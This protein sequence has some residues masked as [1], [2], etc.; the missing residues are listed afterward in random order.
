M[1]AKAFALLTF[2]LTFTARAFPEPMLGSVIQ[3]GAGHEISVIYSE[4][5]DIGSLGNPEN[6][7]VVPGSIAGLRFCATNQGVVLSVTGL[8]TQADAQGAVNISGV[9]DT[10]GNLL[11]AATLQFIVGDLLWATI[12]AN[13][14]GFTSEVVGF[15]D[16]GFDLFSG[17]IQQRDE[18]DDATF[19]GEK[20]SGNFDVKVRI[21][22]VDPA[23]AGAKA[24]IMI[25]EQLDAGKTRPLDPDDPA[26]AFSRYLELSVQAPRTILDQ[27]GAGHQ[28]WQRAASPSI[29]TLS[30]TV[31]NDAAP[32]FTNAWLRIERIGQQFNV[33]RGV[34]G[35]VWQQ[36]GGAT[37]NP[38]LAT[39]VYVGLAFS[40]QNDDIPASSGLRKSFVAKFRDYDLTAT[41]TEENN[42]RIQIV[43]DHAEVQWD[44][45]WTLQTAPTVIGDWADLTT[46]TSPFRVDLNQPMRFFRLKK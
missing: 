29:E 31:T 14:L 5:V 35:V 39:N 41:T 42:L 8:P 21:D 3:H 15:P 24:G 34:D 37:F 17:G 27:P 43:G 44:S 1:K 30:L 13:E 45:N 40:P 33:Y 38:P 20:V 2:L 16:D 18:Y 6:Y 4:P 22:Y 10:S 46:A 19:V 9:M 32:A 26:Q 25:R 11:P 7:S 23:G 12:G 28:I 36:I